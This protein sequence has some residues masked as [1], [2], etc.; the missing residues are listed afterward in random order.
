MVARSVP[1][2]KTRL[3]LNKKPFLNN[4]MDISKNN[5]NIIQFQIDQ[6]TQYNYPFYAT[7]ELA[8]ST[9][10]PFDH[11]PYKYFWRGQAKE[12]C[13]KVIEREAGYRIRHDPC[14]KQLGDAKPCPHSYCWNYP[15]ST[16]YPCCPGKEI[17]RK[18]IEFGQ[19]LCENRCNTQ[20]QIINF[21]P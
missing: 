6:K 20:N 13:P 21:A 2:I 3:L 7:Q 4:K 12:S 11:F 1:K 10:S 19:E 9:L 14:Y 5:R 8:E 17:D 16:I 18:Q 15:C